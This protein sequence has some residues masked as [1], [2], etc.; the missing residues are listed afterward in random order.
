M[1]GADRE[2]HG[3]GLHLLGTI[4]RITGRQRTERFQAI[5]RARQRLDRAAVLLT[6]AATALFGAQS[7]AG[8]SLSPRFRRVYGAG[9]LAPEGRLIAFKS[10]SGLND[11]DDQGNRGRG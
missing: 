4:L 7:R 8:L 5:R 1:A 10:R 6:Y 3:H 2:F 11:H 9:T